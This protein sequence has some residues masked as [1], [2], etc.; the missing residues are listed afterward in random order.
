MIKNQ[1]S[2]DIIF[3]KALT[4]PTLFRNHDALRSD[5]IPDHLPFRNDQITSI[6]QVLAPLLHSSKPSNLLVYGKTGTG[7][8]A[9]TKYV[10]N[11]LGNTCETKHIHAQ[12]IYCNSRTAGTEYR[13]LAELAT[14]IGLSIPFT[15]L[16]VSEVLSR[17]QQHMK[18]NSLQVIFVLDEID[19]LVKSFGD[20]LLY[21]LTNSFTSTTLGFLSLVGISNDLQFKEELGARVLSRLS[22]E[23]IVFPPYSA[24]E[25]KTIL[26]ERAKFA[27]NNNMFTEAAV[28][29]CAALSGSEHGDARRAVDLLRIAGEIAERE[30]ANQL[31]EKHVRVALQK[32]DQDRIGDALK[33][34]PTQA[35]LVLIAVVRN[36]SEVKAS[37][38]SIYNDYSKLCERTG[39]ET[40]TTR[41]VSGLVAELDTLGLVSATVVN[42][43]RYGRT[44]KITPQISLSILQQ[45][46]KSDSTVNQLVEN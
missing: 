33:T 4:S 15:G 6:G 24:M 44:K 9:V 46:F 19:H 17:V 23:E 36:N 12:F 30:G 13:V 10:L 8:T 43:G 16:A 32:I 11:K 21:D 1:D 25:L 22:E 40:L 39:I 31:D 45:A 41:R 42:Y 29:L 5:Y 20:D 28:N 34:L 38:G 14:G 18:A 27:F 7:K 26:Q 35:K 3:G 37:S 2:L